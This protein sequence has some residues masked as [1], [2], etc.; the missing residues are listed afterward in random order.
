MAQKNEI[1]VYKGDEEKP[2]LKGDYRNVIIL[3]FLYVLQ[4]IFD[5][6]FLRKV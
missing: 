6:L 4:G 2:N 5:D 3:F 1:E